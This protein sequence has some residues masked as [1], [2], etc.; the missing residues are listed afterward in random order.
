MFLTWENRQNQLSDF[1]SNKFRNREQLTRND[2]LI[3]EMEKNKMLLLKYWEQRSQH[4]EWHSHC[5][6]RL[7]KPWHPQP[8]HVLNQHS[9]PYSDPWDT[10]DLAKLQGH[11]KKLASVKPRFLQRTPHARKH[12]HHANLC[13]SW[14]HILLKTSDGFT[15]LLKLLCIRESGKKGTIMISLSPSHSTVWLPGIRHVIRATF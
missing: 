6:L 4:G 10:T 2:H 14:R 13:P 7:T 15:N 8:R 3:C 12:A 11:L 1:H 5:I 9:F